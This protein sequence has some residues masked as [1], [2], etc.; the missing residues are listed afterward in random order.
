MTMM[1]FVAKCFVGI[2][3][4]TRW[5]FGMDSEQDTRRT[6]LPELLFD[7]ET[8]QIWRYTTCF[9]GTPHVFISTT[10]SKNKKLEPSPNGTVKSVYRYEI[11]APGY[12]NVSETLGRDCIVYP[13]QE[14]VAFVNGIIPRYIQSVQEFKVTTTDERLETWERANNSLMLNKKFNRHLDRERSR[15]GN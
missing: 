6:F 8:R 1:T 3:L 10:I 13:E 5:S 11:Y 4:P 2:L 15:F 12:I 14:E 9:H 7:G